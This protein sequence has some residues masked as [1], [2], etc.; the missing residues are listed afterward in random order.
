MIF[1]GSLDIDQNLVGLYFD[2]FLTI[3]WSIFDQIFVHF[4]SKYASF[5]TIFQSIFNQNLAHFSSEF[6]SIS[7]QIIH[8]SIENSLHF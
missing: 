3:F 7:T 8:V 4:L 6:G 2:R 5:S 1:D